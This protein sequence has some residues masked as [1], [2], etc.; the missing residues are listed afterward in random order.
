MARPEPLTPDQAP[1]RIRETLEA[2]PPLGVFGT[3]AHAETA[4]RPWLAFGGALLGS[5]ELD[6]K[7]RELVIVRV[8][9]IDGCDYELAQHEQIAVGA[10]AGPEQVAAVVEGRASG[11][12]FGPEEELVLRFVAETIEHSGAPAALAAEVEEAL[13]AR[14]LI[15]LLL[16][17]AHYHGLALLLN[18]TG[19][20]PDP[21]TAMAVVEASSR[22]SSD[23]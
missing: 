18:T 6:P 8:A 4:F 20:Q 19:L 1:A 16:V 9:A 13:S 17:I 2:L 22:P 7:L 10:G 12:E 3:V 5:L 15:E 11:P 21:P 23:G 14:E